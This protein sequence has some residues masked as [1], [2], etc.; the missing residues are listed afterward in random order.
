MKL[1]R[2]AMTVKHLRYS[3]ATAQPGAAS[4]LQMPPQV[5]TQIKLLEDDLEMALFEDRKFIGDRNF[6]RHSAPR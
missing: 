2:A 4:Q 3:W 5:S 1:R 6:K